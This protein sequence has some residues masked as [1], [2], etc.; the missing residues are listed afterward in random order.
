M[1]YMCVCRFVGRPKKKN[2]NMH[3]LFMNQNLSSCLFQ[4]FNC[5]FYCHAFSTSTAIGIPA[6]Y[7]DSWHD[8]SDSNYD[9]S[10]NGWRPCNN[11]FFYL[12]SFHFFFSFSNFTMLLSIN[13]KSLIQ[14]RLRRP[15]WYRI[16]CL[17]L[18]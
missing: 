3:I 15:R 2:K 8:R 12:F 4:H 1:L 5:I 16:Y 14:R 13:W 7:S 18:D 6:L 9:C 17:F 10:W 11:F